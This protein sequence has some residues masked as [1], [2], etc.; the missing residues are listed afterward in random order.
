MS[1]P[2]TPSLPDASHWQAQSLRVTAFLSPSAKIVDPKWW[3]E[4]LGTEAETRSLRPLRGEFNEQGQF[5]KGVLAL[6]V[7]PLRVDW[8]LTPNVGASSEDS[9]L[10]A[11]GAFLEIGDKFLKLMTEWLGL[12]TAPPLQRLAFGAMLLQPV[13]GRDEGYKLLSKYLP[14]VKLSPDSTDF[15]YQINRPRKSKVPQMTARSI[16]RL[17]K[18]SC[19]SLQR[20]FVQHFPDGTTNSSVLGEAVYACSL[21]LDMSTTADFKGEL[22]QQALIQIL[23]E[24]YELG[25]EIASKGDKA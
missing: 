14:S 18:W 16:N 6:Q 9:P 13:D 10:L 17:T 23:R 11:L 7:S 4:L 19:I 1:R 3:S 24:Q 21:E 22:P 12:A 15:L 25:K 8:N 2:K 5:D 20:S